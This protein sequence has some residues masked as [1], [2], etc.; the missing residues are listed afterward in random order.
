MHLMEE[1]KHLVIGYVFL[2]DLVVSHV[3]NWFVRHLSQDLHTGTALNPVIV[4]VKLGKCFLKQRHPPCAMGGFAGAV[5]REVIDRIRVLVP[6]WKAVVDIDADPF[7]VGP[8]VVSEDT[9]P[10]VGIAR[11]AMNDVV[12]PLRFFSKCTCAS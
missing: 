11:V 12:Q 1:I 7:V 4:S 8:E 5:W 2:R 3:E 10:I 6:I 9:L